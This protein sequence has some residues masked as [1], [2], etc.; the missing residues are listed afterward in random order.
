[1]QAADAEF[2]DLDDAEAGAPD[3]QVTDDQP[4]KGE[5]TDRDSADRESSDR[6]AA[7]TLGADRLGAERARR[8]ASR[9]SSFHVF[10]HM[11]LVRARR[12]DVHAAQIA[13]GDAGVVL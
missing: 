13:T 5:R 2:V 12:A 10:L 7:D 6:E 3:R 8:R 11:A 4:A 9:W 1:M